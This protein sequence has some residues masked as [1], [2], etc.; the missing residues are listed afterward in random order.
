MALFNRSKQDEAKA[1]SPKGSSKRAAKQA[2]GHPYTQ[3]SAIG[4][5]VVTGLALSALLCGPLA[6]AVGLGAAARPAI[7]QQQQVDAGLTTTQ[8]KAGGYAVGLVS[9]WLSATK[10][11]HQALGEYLD[12]ATVTSVL[13]TEPWVYRDLSVVSIE[14]PE[15]IDAP[16]NSEFVAVVISASVR[17][18]SYDSEGNARDIWPRR[19]WQVMV[20]AVDGSLKAVGLPAPVEAPTTATAVRTDYGTRLSDKDAAGQTVVD[21]LTAY[22]TGAGEVDRYI[23]PGAEISAIA[24]APFTQIQ[25]LELLGNAEPSQDPRDGEEL[26][27]LATVAAGNVDSRV[28][29]ATYAILLTARAGRW[30]VLSIEPA[31]NI[32]EESEPVDSPYTPDPVSTEIPDPTE[33]PDTTTEENH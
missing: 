21:F 22:L 2:T 29:P 1:V 16:E 5:K 6:L 17:E 3:G 27:V 25:P 10:D 23:T 9:A 32:P 33:T 8:Q 19:Y 13:S 15:N 26:H 12:L 11:D 20:A 24:P 14:E 31:P 7:A 28:L 4:A 18:T 30:E